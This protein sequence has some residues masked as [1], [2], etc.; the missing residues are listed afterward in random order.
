VRWIDESG[1]FHGQ[2]G[3]WDVFN[4]RQTSGGFCAHLPAKS[5]KMFV[6]C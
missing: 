5:R 4:P 3:G 1:H 6:E 2:A